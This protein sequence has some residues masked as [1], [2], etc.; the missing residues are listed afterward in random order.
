M[1]YIKYILLGFLCASVCININK[2][3][4]NNR[5]KD[6]LEHNRMV[7]TDSV[8]T[9]KLKNGEQASTI[10]SYILKKN[11]LEKYI[12]ANLQKI[13]ELEDKLGSKTAYITNIKTVTL[14]D[15][16]VCRDTVLV[17]DNK[18]TYNISYKD[19]W[20]SLNGSSNIQNNK[21][22]TVFDSISVNT[23]LQVGITEDYQIWVTSKNPYLHIDDIEGAV[24]SGSKFNKKKKHFGVGVNAGI[25]AQ[26][27]ITRH[28][29]GF[30]PYVGGGINYNF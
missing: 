14:Y 28:N 29:I 13:K 30:G 11:E 17:K 21:A 19:D 5:L 9:L 3:N 23:P 6:E 22:T 27:D 1:N 4:N 18:L 15:S 20:L 7:M 12:D 16:I 8:R 26:Y 10:N 24:I 2:C 25:G